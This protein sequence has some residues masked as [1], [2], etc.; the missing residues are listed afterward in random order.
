MSRNA[1]GRLIQAEA[2]WSMRAPENFPENEFYAAWRNVVLY[3]EHTWGAHNS[4]SEPDLPF[5]TEQWRIKRRFAVEADSLSRALLAKALPPPNK[6]PIAIEIYNTNSWPRTDLVLL[7][8][9]QSSA[10]D[11]V[12]DEKNN[13]VPSQRL[14]TGEL[15]V[16][17]ENVAP[18]SAKRIGVKKGHAYNRGAVR[19]SARALENNL[20]AL[21]VNK[22]TG[23][24]ENFLWKPSQTQLADTSRGLGL[25]QYLYVPGKNPDDARSLKNVK[26]KIQESGP[27]VASLLIE[28]EA[29]G[30]K[31]YTN[32][33][34]VIDGIGRIDLINTVDKL[35]VR[36]K[37]GVHLAFP[38]NIPNGQFRYDV[39]NGIVRPQFEQLTGACKNFFSTQSWADISN[40]DYG[41]TWTTVDAPLIELGAITAEQPWLQT[42]QPSPLIYSYV[43]NNYWHTNYK[44]DQEGPVQFRYA[45]RPHAEFNPAAAAKFGRECRAPLLACVVDP[46]QKSIS[47][48]FQIEPAEVLVESI[49]P[50]ANAKAWLLYFYNPT[51]RTQQAVLR[52]NKTIPAAIYLSDGFA[53][54]GQ[55]VLDKFEIKAHGSLYVR[56]NKSD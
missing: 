53:N 16:L 39:A 33:I 12:E 37:E 48:L 32:E 9:E 21:S 26:I 17:A 2:L 18:M 3:D 54:L 13:P 5:V 15:A 22:R 19:I 43:M 47:P 1:A 28:A 44:A 27:L 38:F 20:L 35:A 56:V 31:S 49:K 51:A 23:A 8:R 42:L 29:P 4:V 25:N 11:L 46:A 41:V 40:A 36:E 50:I 45:V 34:R 52:W 55:Q 14:S 24:I 30:C 7:S 6:T 10:G